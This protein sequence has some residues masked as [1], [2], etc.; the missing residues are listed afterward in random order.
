L[1]ARG[2]ELGHP[3]VATDLV[4][5]SLSIIRMLRS[6]LGICLAGRGLE[7]GHPVVATGI[8]LRSLSANHMFRMAEVLLVG[9]LRDYP[10]ISPTS[11]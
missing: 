1:A 9:E 7:L 2:L 5:R 6:I 10:V 4:L 3:V 11:T 8:V